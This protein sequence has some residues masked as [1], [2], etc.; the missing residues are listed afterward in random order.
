M[1]RRFALATLAAML[2]GLSLFAQ[3]PGGRV[4]AFI[5]IVNGHTM[6]V[7][8]DDDPDSSN[9]QNIWLKRLS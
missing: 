2:C 3:A 1:F 7:M 6:A 9:N 8:V 4:G 5:H